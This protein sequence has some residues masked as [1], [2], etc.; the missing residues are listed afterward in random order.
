MGRYETTTAIQNKFGKQIAK[1]TIINTPSTNNDIYIRTTS[2]ERLDILA[3]TFYGDVSSWYIIAM[4]NGLGKGTLWVPADTVL[5]IPQINN[6]TD[7][8]T[9]LNNNR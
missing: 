7:Y 8:I 5:R 4:A 1:T 6:F 2:I 9:K 3:N